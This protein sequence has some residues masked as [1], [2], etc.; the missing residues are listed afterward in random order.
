MHVALFLAV[1]P[2]LAHGPGQLVVAG[3]DRPAIT[4]AAERL[5]REEA[6]AADGGQVAAFPALVFGAEAL[7]SIFDD[8]QAMPGGDG[9]D[10]VHVCRLAIEA[11]RHDGAGLGGDRGLDLAGVNVAGIRLRYRRT[12]GWRPAR[13]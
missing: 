1:H 13:R 9:V 8:C 3:E 4:V 10:F 11:D 7:G 12:P 6:S 5:A 2:D